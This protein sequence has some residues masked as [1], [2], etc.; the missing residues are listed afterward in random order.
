MH[1]TYVDHD[2][3]PNKQY[4]FIEEAIRLFDWWLDGSACRLNSRFVSSL[5]PTDL[6]S[7]LRISE[8]RD[9]NL[10]KI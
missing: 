3:P 4:I 10:D 7:D 8:H 9:P 1:Y 6:V 5:P 2:T